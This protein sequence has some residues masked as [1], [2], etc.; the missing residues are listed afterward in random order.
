[1][2]IQVFNNS[3]F[4]SIRSFEENGKT[5]FVASDVAKALGYTNSRKAIGDHCKGVTKRYI[6]TNGGKQEVSIIPE[7]DVYRLITHSKLP[8]AE[9]FESW[10]FDDV[11]PTIRKTGS[12]AAPAL[13][14]TPPQ[15]SNIV[16]TAIY[17]VGENAKMLESIFA[18]KHGMALAVSINMT[19]EQ[20]SVDLDPLKKLVPA[21]EYPGYMNPTQVGKKLGDLRP[22]QVN[23][24]L[25][26]IG[27]QYKDLDT[28]CWRLTEDGKEYGEEKPYTNHGH[29]GYSIAW[30]DLVI[31]LL[32]YKLDN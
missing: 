19:Q 24:L 23:K 7:G 9:K 20:T 29:S 15:A 12:Y 21:E 25:E 26:E 13:N 3:D 1:M 22:V 17:S 4:G 30:N 28:K 16:G 6:P 2:T 5:L 11:L 10:V 27:L 18:L 14:I 31:K 32:K 8:S